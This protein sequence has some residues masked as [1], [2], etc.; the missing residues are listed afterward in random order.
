M[1]VKKW[2][3]PIVIA[4]KRPGKTGICSVWII[5]FKSHFVESW[6]LQG[7]IPTPLIHNFDWQSARSWFR[8]GLEKTCPLNTLMAYAALNFLWA[9][10]LPLPPFTVHPLRCQNPGRLAPPLAVQDDISTFVFTLIKQWSSLYETNPNNALFSGKSHKFRKNTVL[11]WSSSPPK[12][13]VPFLDSSLYLQPS[14][15]EMVFWMILIT[16]DKKS[17]TLDLT[18]PPT[19]LVAGPNLSWQG[20]HGSRRPATRGERYVTIVGQKI[21][22]QELPQCFRDFQRPNGSQGGFLTLENFLAFSV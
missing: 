3:L 14:F 22:T 5:H 19:S 15:F 1:E 20:S 17:V 9:N 10:P 8:E 7:S 21:F 11:V 18:I 2:V 6:K 13:K 12:K 4:L 16:G